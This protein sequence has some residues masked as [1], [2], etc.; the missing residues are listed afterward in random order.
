MSQP[1]KVQEPSMEEILASIR[2]I[3]S[4]DGPET[5]PAPEAAAPAPDAAPAPAPVPQPVHDDVL[6]LTH[7]IE[8]PAPARRSD[9]LV[10]HEAH[11]GAGGAAHASHAFQ[12]AQGPVGRGKYLIRKGSLAGHRATIYVPAGP[13]R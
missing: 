11:H 3:I 10:S 2:K 12:G 6:E 4:E 13:R 8:A 9:P 1:A 5:G 7:E